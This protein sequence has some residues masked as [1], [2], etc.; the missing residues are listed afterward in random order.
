MR[1][2]C[3]LGPQ[4]SFDANIRPRQ[5]P[6]SSYLLSYPRRFQD[7]RKGPQPLYNIVQLFNY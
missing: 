5:A 3:V 4:L 2:F 7:I 6:H 1:I